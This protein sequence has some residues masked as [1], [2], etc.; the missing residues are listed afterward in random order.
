MYKYN[1]KMIHLQTD[2]LPRY[3]EILK[4]TLIIFSSSSCRECQKLNEYLT[5]NSQLYE[6]ENII[7]V[8][9]DKFPKA[10][11]QFKVYFFPTIIKI[12]DKIE[13][14]RLV[15]DQIKNYIKY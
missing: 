14:F 5:L 2:L 7:Y 10:L 6:N 3:L 8:E 9:G 12:K 13:I 11:K 4:N 1:K 15:D